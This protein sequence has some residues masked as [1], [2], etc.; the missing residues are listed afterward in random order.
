VNITEIRVRQR[1]R[2]LAP[3]GHPLHQ[4]AGVVI[5]V[6][7]AGQLWSRQ[8]QRMMTEPL[9]WLTG[10]VEVRLDECPAR[11]GRAASG[12]WPLAVT[13]QPGQLENEPVM[14]TTSP[15]GLAPRKLAKLVARLPWV[16][17]LEETQGCDAHRYGHMPGKALRDPVLFA[18]YACK[19]SARWQF[20]ALLA[21]DGLRG[22]GLAAT[23]GV[24]CWTHLF[25][26]I[27]GYPAEEE[28]YRRELARLREPDGQ[29]LEAHDG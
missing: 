24:Y 5:G 2:I 15:A 29:I 19:N 28:R 3:P 25:C 23:S 18:T 12:S 1:V 9:A 27:R 8:P 14:S 7:T 11:N 17:R 16:T 26:Q 10:Q 6:T 21:S 4:A 20:T 13:V 22:P